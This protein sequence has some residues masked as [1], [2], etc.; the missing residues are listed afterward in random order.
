MTETMNAEKLRD[1]YLTHP[2][3]KSVVNICT[4]RRNWNVCDYGDIYAGAGLECWKQDGKHRCI[5]CTE[6]ERTA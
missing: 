2:A 5:R 3:R 4:G 1:Y 6:K